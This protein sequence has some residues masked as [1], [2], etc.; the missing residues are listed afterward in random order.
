[1]YFPYPIDRYHDER[2]KREDFFTPGICL[3]T[4]DFTYTQLLWRTHKM[5]MLSHA[6]GYQSPCV[7]YH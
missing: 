7:S 3:L 4:V 1:M 2:I 5:I 6:I